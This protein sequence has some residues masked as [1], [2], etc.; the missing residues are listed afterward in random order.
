MT[1]VTRAQTRVTRAVV[2]WYLATHRGG[3]DDTGLPS[4]FMDRSKVGSFAITQAEFAAGDARA[5]FRML[6]TC[7]MFQRLRDQQ[8]LR[9]LREMPP[10]EAREVSDAEQLYALVDAS[11][12]DHLRT[13][14]ALRETCDLAKDS[15]GVGCCSMAPSV[16]CHLKRHTVALKRYGHFGKMPTSIA[17]SIREREVP[18]LPALYESVLRTHRTRRGRAVALEAA[19]CTAWRVHQKIASMFLSLVCNPDLASD[20]PWVNGIDWTYYVVVDSNVDLFLASIGYN[21]LKTYDARRDFLLRLASTIDLREMDRSLSGFNPRLVQQALYLF[22]SSA[23][24]RTATDD[25]MHAAKCGTCPR[26]LST[27]CPVSVQT[28]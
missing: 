13:T 10:I 16:A 2:A 28:S 8:I 6:V 18:S 25:C 7:A 5:L 1:T 21:G 24:R 22:M 11:P 20:P 17:L 3:P 4:M 19:L 26:V 9:I 23:N 15:H 27:R 12:C 14:T